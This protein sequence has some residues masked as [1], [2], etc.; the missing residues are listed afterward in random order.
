MPSGSASRHPQ[1]RRG[2]LPGT[3]RGPRMSRADRE[4]Q[5][6]DVAEQV[7]GE[8]SYTETTMEQVAARAGITKPVIYDHFGSKERLLTAVVERARD[9]LTL[10]LST[11]F[12]GVSKDATP[13]DYFRLGVLA[14]MEFFDERRS[15]FTVYQQEAAVA[16]AAGS[17]IEALRHTQ[18]ELLISQF[19]LVPGVAVRPGHLRRG[20]VEIII[21]ANERVAGWRLRHPEVTSEQ[22]TDL[23]VDTLWPG[24]EVMLGIPA[25]ADH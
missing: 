25:T 8:H 16:A 1:R 17:D 9:D 10:R 11:A 6:L 3:P 24:I 7:F 13:R 21:A 23:V 4:Q 19:E 22:A 15:S 2:P 12:E 18:V 20:V 5:L 14:F